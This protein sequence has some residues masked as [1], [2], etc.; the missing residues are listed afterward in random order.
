MYWC[1]DCDHGFTDLVEYP[2]DEPDASYLGCPYCESDSYR[3]LVSEAE[4]LEDR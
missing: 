4:A 2:G 1:R 3:D